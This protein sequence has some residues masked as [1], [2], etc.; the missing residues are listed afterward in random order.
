MDTQVLIIGGG[1]LGCCAAWHLARMGLATVLVEAGAINSAASGQNAG[2]LHFQIER[3]FL[4]QGTQAAELGSRIVALNRLAVAEWAGLEAQLGRPLDIHQHGGLMVAQSDADMDLLAFKV[5]REN[6]LGLDTQLLDRAAL[7]GHAP[8]LSPDLHGAAWLSSEGHANPRILSAAF[9]HAALEQG[10]HIH[11]HT[12]VTG[13][14]M[15]DDGT[16]VAQLVDQYGPRMIRARNVLLAA[17]H[18]CARIASFL[19]LN[20][21]LVPVPLTMNVT[22]RTR[23]FLPYLIQHVG[24]RLSMKQTGDGNIMVGGGWSSRLAKGADGLPDLD[25]PAQLVSA[26]VRANLA[27][28]ANVW[29]GLRQ[30]SLLRSWTGITCISADQLPI[31]GM[32]DAAPG[33][34]VAA[35]GSMFTLGP[36]V[37]RLLAGAIATGIPAPEL[38]PFSPARFAHLNAFAV[39]P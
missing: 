19:G 38:A 6:A 15:A 32:I 4:E 21:P 22:D 11:G 9:A 30:R 28:A 35:G 39:L 7:R 34:F 14:S 33:L 25:Q 16:Y 26:N 24:R 18:W 10:V 27:V 23:A 37:A 31:A 29:P 5:A 36:L 1:L 13:L 2:S 20:I 17:G 8:Y 3:R 12:K